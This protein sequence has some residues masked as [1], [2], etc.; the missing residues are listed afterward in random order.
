MTG[1]FESLII[2]SLWNRVVKLM[3]KWQWTST[4]G[5]QGIP[6]A[7]Y[8]SSIGKIG[9][10]IIVN[11]QYLSKYSLVWHEASKTY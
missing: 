9:Q 3:G 7:I 4:W 8:Y 2:C 10:C 6:T 1:V 5:F 11:M